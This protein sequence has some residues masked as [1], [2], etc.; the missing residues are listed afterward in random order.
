TIKAE[1]INKQIVELITAFIENCDTY[2]NRIKEELKK[3]S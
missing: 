1:G 2:V 3:I